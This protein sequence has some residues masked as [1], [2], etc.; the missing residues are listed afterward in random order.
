MN[1]S[2]EAR[3]TFRIIDANLNRVGEGLRLLEDIAR[4]LL[5]DAIL[6]EQLKAMRH[7]LL[8]SEWAFQQQLLQSRNSEGDVGIDMEVA[9]EEK[10]RDIPAILVSNSRRVQESL[11]V[12]EEMAKAPGLGLDPEKFKKA[13]FALYTI[14]KSLFSIVLRQDKIKRLSPDGRKD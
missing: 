4:L 13:R 2:K 9:G 1:L 7:K 14:E 10:Q 12:M 8:E 11:R 3:Q 5:N 6:T